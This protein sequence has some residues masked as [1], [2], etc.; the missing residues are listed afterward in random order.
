M[1]LGHSHSLL[2]TMN[3]AFEASD[4]EDYRHDL[5]IPGQYATKWR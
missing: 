5:Y 4:D 2:S 3:R 1:T